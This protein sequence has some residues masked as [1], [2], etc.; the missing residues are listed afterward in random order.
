[1]DFSITLCELDTSLQSC[2]KILVAFLVVSWNIV[3]CGHH[4]FFTLRTPV[5]FAHQTLCSTLIF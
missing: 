4:A 2:I 1:M 3:V 5:E